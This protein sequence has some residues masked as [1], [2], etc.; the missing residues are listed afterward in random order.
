M[1]GSCFGVDVF[2]R[3]RSWSR[4]WVRM[5]MVVVEVRVGRLVEARLRS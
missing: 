1:S 3:S 2:K 5:R 4:V